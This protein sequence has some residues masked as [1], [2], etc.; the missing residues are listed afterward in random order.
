[1]IS[2]LLQF[3][4]LHNYQILLIL[5]QKLLTSSTSMYSQATAHNAGSN[6]THNQV[7]VIL[8]IMTFLPT[9]PCPPPLCSQHNHCNQCSFKHSNLT[10]HGK[11]KQLETAL[12]INPRQSAVICNPFATTPVFPTGHWSHERLSDHTGA[13]HCL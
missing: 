10:G 12:K 6:P 4:H 9:F 8:S 3:P 13:C 2:S 7:Q 5:L 1:M 11:R